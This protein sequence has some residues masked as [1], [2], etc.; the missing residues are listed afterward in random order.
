MRWGIIQ[1]IRKKHFLESIIWEIFAVK[2][3]EILVVDIS[4]KI[5]LI[6]F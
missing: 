3:E 1:G 5:L 2:L 4:G 6:M